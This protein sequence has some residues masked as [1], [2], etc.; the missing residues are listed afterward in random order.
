MALS[1]NKPIYKENNIGLIDL[2]S[3]SKMVVRCFA[4]LIE[5]DSVITKLFNEMLCNNYQTMSL[6]AVIHLRSSHFT[7]SNF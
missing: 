6:T 3:M 7:H 5:S 4:K 2:S 1:V